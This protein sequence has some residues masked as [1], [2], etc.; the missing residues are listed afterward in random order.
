MGKRV[1]IN[2]S[3]SDNARKVLEKRYLRKDDQGK[4]LET[5]EDMF[6]RVAQNI[7]GADSSYG[8][9]PEEVR[10]TGEEFFE[11]MGS[12]EFLPNSPTLMNAG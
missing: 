6:R 11:L 9:S 5:A 1:D 3:L 4:V 8:S 7:A 10:R 12:L 2:S